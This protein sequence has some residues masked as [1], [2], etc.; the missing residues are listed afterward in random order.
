MPSF[1]YV[2]CRPDASIFYVG[3]GGVSRCNHIVS[4]FRRNAHHQRIVHKYGAE[5][6]LVGKI[7]C[8]TEKIAFELEAG[9]IK[10]L[11]RANVVL[12][13][14]TDGGEG[15]S[16]RAMSAEA[17]KKLSDSLLGHK[18][19]DETK[20]KIGDGNR[21]K[22]ISQEVRNRIS[23]SM[24]GKKRVNVAPFSE[25]R[26]KNQS[27]AMMGRKVSPETRQKISV[28]HKG[29]SLSAS[30]VAALK[31]AWAKRKALK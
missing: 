26:R 2:H 5:N 31:Q 21:G 29:K 17:R 25:E 24:T 16:G 8:S 12:A 27:T 14:Y 23:A 10:C 7:E 15:A 18:I 19:S 20:R 11:R 28:A 30:H 9:L 4:K 3:K 22:T 13:N 6:I 1:A